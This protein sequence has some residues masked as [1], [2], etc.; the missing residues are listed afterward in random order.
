MDKKLK[1][2][3]VGLG[4]IGHGHAD[5]LLQ[6]EYA[7]FIAV[8]DPKGRD[9]IRPDTKVVF[10]DSIT[11]YTDFDEFIEKSGV[12]AIIISAPD[13][14]HCEYTVKAL[15]RG[16]H[17]MCEKPLAITDDEARQMA[18]AAKKSTARAFVGQI[19]RFTPA[20]VKARE[21]I[22]EGV[23]GDV[24]CIESQYRHNCHENL[25]ETDWRKVDPRHATACGGCHAIDIVRYFI[26]EAPEEVFAFGNQFCRKDWVVEDASET[27]MKFP[28]G[29]IAR[30][31]TSLGSI[32][33]YSMH[34]EIYGTKASVITDNTWTKVELHTREMGENGYYEYK[35]EEIPVAVNNHNCVDQVIEMCR[36]ILFGD[37][38]RHEIV[39]GAKSLY[40][41]NGAIRSMANGEK[42]V[43]D[44]S[45]LY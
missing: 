21:L 2:G 35:V 12:E 8:C 22:D 26:D 14:V 32:S 30:V 15:E 1:F 5:S 19:C 25:P 37:K 3:L 24:F 42:V 16:I 31:F 9:A 6:C 45:D 23:L 20:F 33:P 29:A 13:V 34:T 17:V 4:G 44:Y 43:L 36:A 18:Q 7:D 39:E 38:A 10:P 27:V 28:S 41:C 11:F 40:V